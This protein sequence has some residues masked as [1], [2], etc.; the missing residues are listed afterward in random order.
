MSEKRGSP[1][2]TPHAN[3]HDQVISPEDPT[4]AER[5]GE[6]PRKKV[7]RKKGS[8]V[9]M[10][11]LESGGV[12]GRARRSVF[13]DPKEKESLWKL[14]DS[15]KEILSE[16]DSSYSSDDSQFS[17][18]SEDEFEEGIGDHELDPCV[19]H[20]EG[21]R[22]LPVKKVVDVLRTAVTCKACVVK[23]HKKQIKKI[24]AF[25][26]QYEEDVER[27]EERKFFRS[28]TDRL[29]WRLGRQK[30]VTELYQ[31]FLG[32]QSS[33]YGGLESHLCC[34]FR[35]GEETYGVATSIF[36]FCARPRKPHVFCIEANK[37]GPDICK[38]F[39]GNARGKHYAANYK[40]AAA[41]QQMG[42]GETDIETLCG[43]MDL[44]SSASCHNHI[45]QA[46]AMA[47]PIQISLQKESEEEARFHE[48]ELTKQIYNS[49]ENTYRCTIEG[50]EYGPFEKVT[51]CIGKK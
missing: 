12:G 7:G 34:D 3:Q 21:N 23:K 8:K 10:N 9:E 4:Q 48:I 1:S 20:L 22:I 14:D 25:C 43:F 31:I 33:E 41:M 17:S 38:T 16:D 51:G 26:S 30:K 40:M 11:A 19:S 29:E 5:T 42:V 45:R 18:E 32:K 37:I 13:L 36:G 44:P 47:G 2:D 50:H 28:R 27:E 49:T 15:C 39:H 46:E 6:P 35:V 24:L